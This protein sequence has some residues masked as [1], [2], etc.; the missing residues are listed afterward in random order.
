MCFTFFGFQILDLRCDKPTLSFAILIQMQMLFVLP[1]AARV[2]QL[3]EISGPKTE[4]HAPPPG[5]TREH[6]GGDLQW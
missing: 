3:A 4:R 1:L 5:A 6:R 2:R